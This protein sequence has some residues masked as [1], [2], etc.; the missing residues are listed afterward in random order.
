M[1]CTEHCP[2]CRPCFPW[3]LD[4]LRV[5]L[6]VPHLTLKEEMGNCGTH[7]NKQNPQVVILIAQLPIQWVSPFWDKQNHRMANSWHNEDLNQNM[8]MHRNNQSMKTEQSMVMINVVADCWVNGKN[9]SMDQTFILVFKLLDV[10]HRNLSK[11]QSPILIPIS[12]LSDII[13]IINLTWEVTKTK[14]RIA[15]CKVEWQTS[16]QMI[17][18]SKHFGQLTIHTGSDEKSPTTLIIHSSFVLVR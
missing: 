10:L 17:K 14:S 3:I 5:D 1:S 15:R 18:D 4:K 6:S 2:W 16:H 8:N 12:V 11:E 9:E 7:I 13:L